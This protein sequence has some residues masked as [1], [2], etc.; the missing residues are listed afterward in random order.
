MWGFEGSNPYGDSFV[1]SNPGFALRTLFEDGGVHFFAG[2]ARGDHR[3][4]SSKSDATIFVLATGCERPCRAGKSRR[5]R[6]PPAIPKS[7]I[8]PS[9]G[10]LTTQPITDTKSSR[11]HIR[12]S[13][14]SSTACA[15]RSM[16]FS[17]ASA[18]RTRNQVRPGCEVQVPQHFARDEE[19]S[20]LD[21]PVKRK[22]G[23]CRPH[24][25]GAARRWLIR[26]FSPFRRAPCRLPSGRRGTARPSLSAM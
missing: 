15:A 4:I 8:C 24:H 18:R 10:P 7:A 9:P 14:R 26:G 2:A 17:T 21:R 13:R 1:D 12:A 11:R 19:T 20:S 5:V 22:A 3:S 6:V 16:S 23:W 25:R